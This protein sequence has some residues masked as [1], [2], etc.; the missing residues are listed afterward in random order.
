MTFALHPGFTP[1]LSAFPTYSRGAMSW[2]LL[3]LAPSTLVALLI[4]VASQP[5]LGPILPLL[6]SW[7]LLCPNI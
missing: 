3:S 4:T 6:D 2:F 1:P 7:R 5:L